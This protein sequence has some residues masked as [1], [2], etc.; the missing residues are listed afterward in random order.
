MFEHTKAFSGFS[1]DDVPK[2]REF[3]ERTLGLRVSE[4][5][6]MLTLHIAGDRDV[7][8]YPKPG[9]EPAT[10]TILNFPVPDIEAAVDALTGLGVVFERLPGTDGKGVNRAGGPLIAW[11]KDPAGNWLS[12]IQ[13]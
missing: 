9:H 4:A 13:E 6:G 2:A 7:L 8:V 5:N 10:F 1:V 3:Y 11:F 12:V